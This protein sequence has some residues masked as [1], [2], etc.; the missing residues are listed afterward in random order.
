MARTQM[1]T[2]PLEEYKELLLKDRP[3]ELDKA[4]VERFI[5]TLAEF[6]DYEED[7]R[8]YWSSSVGNHLRVHDAEKLVKE[9]LLALKYTDFERFMDLWNS[10]ATA[11]REKDAQE[12]M[13]R[14]MNEARE[15]RA[16][17]GSQ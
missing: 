5:R 13:I 11:R 2:I 3:S 12:A 6:L 17:G 15:I 9:L 14:Q 16:E 10:V 4:I 1:V 7:E 8:P